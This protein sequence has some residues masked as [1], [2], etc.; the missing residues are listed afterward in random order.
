MAWLRNLTVSLFSSF[1]FFS[2]KLWL[3]CQVRLCAHL[4]GTALFGR[5]CAQIGGKS[6]S[7]IIVIKDIMTSVGDKRCSTAWW[8]P[9]TVTAA[10]ERA[11]KVAT[12]VKKSGL[13]C[14]PHQYSPGWMYSSIR[15]LFLRCTAVWQCRKQ[16]WHRLC[17]SAPHTASLVDRMTNLYRTRASSTKDSG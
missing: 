9:D 1:S 17:I 14:V 11:V 7:F 6:L 12:V 13:G 8:K 3:F 16:Q 2:F 5:V 15:C 4:S 10:V